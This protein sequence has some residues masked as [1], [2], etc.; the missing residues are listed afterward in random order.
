M[1][2]RHDPFNPPSVKS[3]GQLYR[4]PSPSEL[5]VAWQGY[6]TVVGWQEGAKF[7]QP[8]DANGEL[9][10]N[11]FA[12]HMRAAMLE[13]L[14]KLGSPEMKA[15]IQFL[16]G[17]Y[18]DLAEAELK[19]TPLV[20]KLAQYGDYVVFMGEVLSVAES[21][22]NCVEDE[23]ADWQSTH[24]AEWYRSAFEK[25]VNTFAWGPPT[26]D[27]KPKKIYPTPSAIRVTEQDVN[28]QRVSP[29]YKAEFD[30]FR[31][32]MGFL[33]LV[34][35]T[36]SLYVRVGMAVAVSNATVANLMRNNGA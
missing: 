19:F 1:R 31:M 20:N 27:G 23:F 34:V 11:E 10:G 15:H 25:K 6:T 33:R 17:T 12:Q 28:D 24:R 14:V 4:R 29:P 3:E 8:Y 32:E 30:R 5:E 21:L 9:R 36:M 18:S 13:R 22:L 2:F 7:F 26:A 16:T 35:R